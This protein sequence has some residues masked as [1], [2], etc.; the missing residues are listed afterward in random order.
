MKDPVEVMDNTSL[1]MQNDAG[2]YQVFRT[3]KKLVI[4]KELFSERQ[5]EK[6]KETLES[7]SRVKDLFEV[8]FQ[9][10]R[11][12]AVGLDT[13][14]MEMEPEKDQ[15]LRRI[16]SN[17][18]DYASLFITVSN[19][20][21]DSKSFF[22]SGTLSLINVDSEIKEEAPASR[23]AELED[24]EMLTAKSKRFT[25]VRIFDNPDQDSKEFP[26]YGDISKV[27][28]FAVDANP[29]DKMSVGHLK[30]LFG[31]ENISVVYPKNGYRASRN[32]IDELNHSY[33]KTHSLP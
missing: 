31:R 12:V 23:I 24:F 16:L 20:T 9:N 29:V 11:A 21:E 19:D 5:L 17:K 1:G 15:V 22:V 30:D 7:Q 26:D 18:E 13:I 33:R 4:P 32:A 14:D 3:L 8:Y 6:I 27:Q 2:V 28:V 25:M 10:G